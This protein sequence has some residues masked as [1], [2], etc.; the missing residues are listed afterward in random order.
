MLFLLLFI[1]FIESGC[2][3]TIINFKYD[4]ECKELANE[5]CRF[6]FIF[7]AQFY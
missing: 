3:N 5:F 2:K 1:F 4:K 6:L 7:V